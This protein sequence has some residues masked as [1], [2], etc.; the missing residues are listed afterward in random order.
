MASRDL[1]SPSGAPGRERLL[2]LRAETALSRLEALPARAVVLP[3]VAFQWLLVGILAL[4][5]GHDGWTYDPSLHASALPAIVLAQ[6]L[7]LLPLL[8]VLVH[9]LALRIAGRAFA[10]WAALVW[11]LLPFAG[12]LY[13]NRGFRT[14]Y[15]RSFLVHLAGLTP[16]PALPALAAFAGA[17]LLALRTDRWGTRAA[18]GAAVLSVAGAAFAPRAALVAAAPIL[19]LLLRK[20]PRQAGAVAAAVA[21]LLGVTA[22]TGRFDG[23]VAV[24]S[25]HT[26]LESVAG[27]KEIFWS[28]RVLEWATIGGALALLR[29]RRDAGAAIALASVLGWL[30]VSGSHARAQEWGVALFAAALPVWFAV[31]LGVASLPLLLPRG[32]A[33]PAGETLLTWWLRLRAPSFSR[34]AAD[35]VL[36]M[37]LWTAL[38]VAACFGTALFVGLWNAA[39]YPVYLGYDAAEHLA[40]ADQLLA[41]GGIP[42][43]AQGGEYYTP[44]GFYAVAAGATWVG[45]HLGMAEPHRAALYLNVIFVL[46]TAALLLVLARMLFPR[47]PVVWVAALGFFTFLP[48]VPKSAAMFYP[49]ALN[50][51]VATAAIAVSVRILVRRD[52]S[53]RWLALL[54]ALLGAGQLVRAS[55]LFTVAAVALT[56]AVALATGPIRRQISWKRVGIAAAAAV[57]LASPWYARQ[58][59]TYHRQP[60]YVNNDLAHQLFNPVPYPGPR[61]P[62][63]GLPLNDVLNRPVRPFFNNQALAETYSEIWGDWSGHYAW[64]GYSEGPSTQSLTVL[65]NQS[66]LGILPTA[67]ALAGWLGLLVLAVRRRRLP[68]LPVVLL[69]A[70]ALLAYFW[71]SYVQLTPS[72]DLFKGSYLLTT[73]PLWALAFGYAVERAS[74]RRPVVAAGLAVLFLVSAVVDLQ[75]VLYGVRDHR[76]PF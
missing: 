6:V 67:F 27:L 16:D 61:P 60:L 17:V 76:P 12:V 18:A 66:K 50:M 8:V 11:V 48:V 63:F 14:T 51:L 45:R 70:V 34:A 33:R 46:A 2:Q 29:G 53:L 13:A 30:S 44:P 58:V 49:E 1:A 20:R 3:L 15:V 4:R 7:L 56:F 73:A 47:R 26:A 41:G 52:F 40:Y 59:I 35:R 10:A 38:A 36:A 31:S 24:F 25:L 54:A 72:G 32:E 28:G 75:F 57:V 69:P 22:A 19:A 23:G 5:A 37:P 62:Y 68:L 43:Q 42:S 65:Q 71:R 55:S 9:S 74:R 64:S 21:L 39:R